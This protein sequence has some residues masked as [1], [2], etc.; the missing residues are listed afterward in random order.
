[1]CDSYGVDETSW[2]ARPS[3]AGRRCLALLARALAT[4]P[5]RAASCDVHTVRQQQIRCNPNNPNQ[6]QQQQPQQQQHQQQL[7]VSHVVMC[8]AK[9]PVCAPFRVAP[10]R[11]RRSMRCAPAG[12]TQHRCALQP[13]AAHSREG[14]RLWSCVLS[15]PHRNQL[16]KL[17]V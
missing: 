10:Q 5:A 7:C 9:S 3:R 8:M 15:D 13:R 6:Q 12:A 1:M 2:A 14:A 4:M 17:D 16:S 11:A